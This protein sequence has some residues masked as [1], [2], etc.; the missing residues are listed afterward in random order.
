[1]VAPDAPDAKPPGCPPGWIHGAG[2]RARSPFSANAPILEANGL[3]VVIE[4]QPSDDGLAVTAYDNVVD[5]DGVTACEIEAV[6]DEP[7]AQFLAD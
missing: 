4:G 5:K 2:H 3:F 7:S 1:V 6:Y